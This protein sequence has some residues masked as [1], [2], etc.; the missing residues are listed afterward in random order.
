MKKL[1]FFSLAVLLLSCNN[2]LDTPLD[3]FPDAPTTLSDSRFD[4]SFTDFYY[5]QDASGIEE[6]TEYTSIDF[7]RSV[8]KESRSLNKSDSIIKRRHLGME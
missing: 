4:S 1:I 3:I 7:D 6:D 5:W 2:G 8:N